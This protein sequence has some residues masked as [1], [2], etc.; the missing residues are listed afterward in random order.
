[1]SNTYNYSTIVENH[2]HSRLLTIKI[3]ILTANHLMISKHDWQKS[4]VNPKYIHILK[5]ELQ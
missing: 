3:L 1:M 2:A 5:L 4:I